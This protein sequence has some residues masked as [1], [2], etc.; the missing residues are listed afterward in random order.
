MALVGGGKGPGCVTVCVTI[1]TRCCLY[2][3]AYVLF[4]VG[5]T[6]CTVFCNLLSV[7]HLPFASAIL[8]RGLHC[9]AQSR[10]CRRMGRRVAIQNRAAC[11]KRTTYKD[12]R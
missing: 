8:V 9:A 5:Y 4:T 6:L 10:C 3:V 11:W 2:A 7:Q 12:F 1:N